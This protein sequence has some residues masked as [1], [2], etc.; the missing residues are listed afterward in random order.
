MGNTTTK[1]QF[2]GREVLLVEGA[3]TANGYQVYEVDGKRCWAN[4]VIGQM[5]ENGDPVPGPCTFVAFCSNDEA[6]EK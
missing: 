5:N 3:R 4:V 2:A 1:V 6:A